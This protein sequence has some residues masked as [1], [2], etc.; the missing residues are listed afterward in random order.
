M[1]TYI[2]PL[3]AAV[4]LFAA[5]VA[6]AHRAHDV[7]PVRTVYWSAAERGSTVQFD[8]LRVVG[9]RSHSG[10][11]AAL[12][13]EWISKGVRIRVSL[14]QGSDETGG[15]FVQRFKGLVD[16]TKLAFPPDPP[17]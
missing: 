9:P 8:N 4:L 3:V 17:S 14:E 5:P 11:P 6:T 16:D 12:S 10:H 15:Y 13:A 7:D 1:R 2:V